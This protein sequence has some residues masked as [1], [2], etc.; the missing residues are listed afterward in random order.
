MFAADEEDEFDGH[1]AG[2]AAD[3]A[4]QAAR[5]AV[6]LHRA[7]RRATGQ[8]HLGLLRW[9]NIIFYISNIIRALSYHVDIRLK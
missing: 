3:A 7:Q 4:G 1:A 2:H 6:A 9:G 8:Q 5:D